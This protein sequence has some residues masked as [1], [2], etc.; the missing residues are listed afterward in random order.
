MFLST[1]DT[2]ALIE[3]LKHEQYSSESM[4]RNTVLPVHPRGLV[5]PIPSS[6]TASNGPP[7]VPAI[8]PLTYF[9]N[10]V[11]L[12][13]VPSEVLT[14]KL[15]CIANLQ[16]TAFEQDY[17]HWIFLENKWK[18]EAWNQKAKG[19]AHPRNG[20]DDITFPEANPK[21]F[22]LQ[23]LKWVKQCV[24]TAGKTGQP[25]PVINALPEH[26]RAWVQQCINEGL[27][28]AEGEDTDDDISENSDDSDAGNEDAQLYSEP[29]GNG[30]KVRI[31]GID[32]G[33]G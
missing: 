17:C 7:V 12:P 8:L 15:A 24:R 26:A 13:H 5:L 2:P 21:T 30:N 25:T 3:C 4:H 31:G 28:M 19:Q 22:P 18:P 32:Q 27:A 1:T 20:P 29:S 23:A 6:V 33:T 11:A 9:T 10:G 16:D 14:N